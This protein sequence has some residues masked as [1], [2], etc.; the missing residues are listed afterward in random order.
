MVVVVVV[1]VVVVVVGIVAIVIQGPV[2]VSVELQSSSIL[3][4]SCTVKLLE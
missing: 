4:C 1:A 3:G 2:V